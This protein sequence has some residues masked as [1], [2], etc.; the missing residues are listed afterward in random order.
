MWLSVLVGGQR[1]AADGNSIRIS[2]SVNTLLI[3]LL[4]GGREPGGTAEEVKSGGCMCC[5][6]LRRLEGKRA[7]LSLSSLLG[8]NQ[9]AWF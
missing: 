4:R 6:H 7:R 2:S 9:G 8:V 5:R 1:I 3:L